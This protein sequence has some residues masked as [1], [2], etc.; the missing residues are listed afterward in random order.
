MKDWAARVLRTFVQGAVGAFLL[1]YSG[2]IFDLVRS[3]ASLGPGDN[4][5]A[6][7]DMNFFRNML[8]AMAAAGVIASVSLLWNGLEA[9]SGK[10]L[11]KPSS[12]PAPKDVE[13]VAKV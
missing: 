3:F 8:F 11:L 13:P 5:P 12:P 2:T 6:F 4:L 7:P 9:W 1:L 10:G